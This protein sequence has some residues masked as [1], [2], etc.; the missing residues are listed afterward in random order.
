MKI[1]L[2]NL[3][4]TLILILFRLSLEAL[5]FYGEDLI[6]LL[7]DLPFIPLNFINLLTISID[8]YLFIFLFFFLKFL[9]FKKSNFSL[10]VI[11][12][13][14]ILFI[15]YEFYKSDTTNETAS[16]RIFLITTVLLLVIATFFLCFTLLKY[17]G[18]L[19]KQLKI[20][21]CFEILIF[22][23]QILTPLSKVMFKMEYTIYFD[24][25]L[26]AV[27]FMPYVA[28]FLLYYKASK[29]QEPHIESDPNILDSGEYSV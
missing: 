7:V 11:I 26:I 6:T 29:I 24:Y 18:I 8:L 23:V 5:I 22:V 1:T 27:S 20:Y 10:L 21:A 19:Q 15:C 16:G 14:R 25:V 9:D 13:M 12:A 28:L 2:F 4:T 17:Q 3:R